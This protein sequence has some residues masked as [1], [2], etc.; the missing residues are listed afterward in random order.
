MNTSGSSKPEVLEITNIEIITIGVAEKGKPT[1][2]WSFFDVR[3]KHGNTINKPIP[4]TYFFSKATRFK[5][6]KS[7]STTKKFMIS[8]DLV[9]QGN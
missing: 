9:R 2:R 7:F 3:A 5:L 1:Y 4:I 6:G 8:C